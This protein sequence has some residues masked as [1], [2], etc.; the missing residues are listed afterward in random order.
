MRKV[1]Y[2]Q[3]RSHA[4][5]TGPHKTLTAFSLM[6]ALAIVLACSIQPA[7]G[8]LQPIGIGKKGTA[9]SGSAFPLS[10]RGAAEAVLTTQTF[11]PPI[12]PALGLAM[13]DFT[14]DTHPDLATVEVERFD[15]SIAHYWIEIRLTEGG[16]QILR[17]TAPFGGLLITPRDVT[18]DGNLDLVVRSA[19]SHAPVAVFLNDGS[20]H[21]SKADLAAFTNVLR[22]GTSQFGFTTQQT[23]LGAPLACLE[24]YTAECPTGSL[25]SLR[26]QKG[27]LPSSGHRAASQRFLSSGTNRAP[28]SLA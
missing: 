14:G 9:V 20:G 4:S 11:A 12:A 21:F 19:K 22:D 13:A 18:G 10:T 1:L 23:Y 3:E 24:S 28:P 7:V 5:K 26:E 15:S 8:Q 16:H 17:L 2:H 27:S 25:R 6:L